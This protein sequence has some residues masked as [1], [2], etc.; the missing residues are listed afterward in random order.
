[1]VVVIDF[2]VVSSDENYNT[3]CGGNDGDEWASVVVVIVAA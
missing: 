1:M 2:V 3:N